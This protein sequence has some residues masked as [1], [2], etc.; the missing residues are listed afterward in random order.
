LIDRFSTVSFGR[1]PESGARR[2]TAT[3]ALC[4]QNMEKG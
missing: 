4:L 2:G 3:G 1:R